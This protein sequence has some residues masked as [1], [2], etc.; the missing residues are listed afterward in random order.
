MMDFIKNLSKLG[1]ELTHSE[2]ER[3]SIWV[4]NCVCL[5]F[6]LASFIKGTSEFFD[7]DYLGVYICYGVII[8][9]FLILQLTAKGCFS[10][11]KWSMIVFCSS[12]IAAL[13]AMYG[14]Q[15]GADFII[16][17][18][19]ALSLLFFHDTY[20]FGL[21]ILIVF[22][23]YEIGVIAYNLKG[24]L[25]VTQDSFISSYHFFFF[26]SCF[27]SLLVFYLAVNGERKL[28]SR[29]N[30][31]LSRLKEKQKVITKS[32]EELTLINTELERFVYMASHDLK[33]PMRN[34]T[35]FLGLIQNKTKKYND[36]ELEE[37][38]EFATS[39]SKQMYELIDDILTYSKL[40]DIDA[41]SENV[42]LNE[43]LLKVLS[44]LKSFISDNNAK[45]DS[46]IL[47]EIKSDES[48]MIMLFQNIIENGIKYNRSEKPHVKIFS[49]IKNE[50]I[51]VSISDNGIG[52]DP[53]YQSK[54]FEMFTRLHNIDEFSGTGIGL[55]TCKRIMHHTGG[56]IKIESIVDAGSK[57]ILTWPIEL[58]VKKEKKYRYTA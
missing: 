56:E 36:K 54:I 16:T 21:A 39:N 51:V 27:C 2:N 19:L 13:K 23:T 30:N 6:I 44:N 14:P 12:A 40:G 17:I 7:Q 45:V 52:I 50:N 29:L 53:E 22:I 25:I 55:A 28:S 43:V 5:V 42:D 24:P 20:K 58:L 26:A 10:L 18:V 32:N 41:I 38:L 8:A 49:E 33:T 31:L 48:R 47:P 35:S 46:V 34:V 4:L 37:Y 1:L 3:R 57:L 11:S 9:M 15:L